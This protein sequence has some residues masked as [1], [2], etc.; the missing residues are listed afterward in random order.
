[1]SRDQGARRAKDTANRILTML[2]AALNRAYA[3]EANGIPSDRAWRTVKPFRDVGRPRT[4]A[5]EAAQRQRL[6]NATSGAFRNL[7]IAILLTGS[8][9]APGEIAQARVRDFHPDLGIIHIAHSKTGRRDVPLTREG[10]TFF[11]GLAA[12]RDPDTLLLPKDDGTA[13]GYNHQVRPMR[14][15]AVRAKLPKGANMYCLR[16]TFATEHIMR[17]TDLVSLADLMGTSVRMLEQHYAHVI[18]AHKRKL[19]EAADFKLG[20]KKSNVVSIDKA[21]RK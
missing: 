16:H 18:A 7:V 9:P 12:G 6:I 21:A 2:K 8:R 15:A 13:W 5:L 4:I 10:I 17:G 1:M 14:E 20:L 3:D 19:V 11:K